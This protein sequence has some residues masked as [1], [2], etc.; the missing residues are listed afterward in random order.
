ME[1]VLHVQ[2]SIISEIEILLGE[3]IHSLVEDYGQKR[4]VRKKRIMDR[5]K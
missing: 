1:K 3:I 5:L 4:A 2:R